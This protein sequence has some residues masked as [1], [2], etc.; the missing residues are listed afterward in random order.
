MIRVRITDLCK[1]YLDLTSL[2][3]FMTARNK[4]NTD[5][6]FLRRQFV[7]S[8]NYL[9]IRFEETNNVIKF[10]TVCVLAYLILLYRVLIRVFRYIYKLY[11]ALQ[12]SE[13]FTFERYLLYRWR[14]SKFDKFARSS[15]VVVAEKQKNFL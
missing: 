14:M 3:A 2:S 9:L 11:I 15:I 8:F 1:I 7:T 4:P 13:R 12:M 5:I 6:I 10:N